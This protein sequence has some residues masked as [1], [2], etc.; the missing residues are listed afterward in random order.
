MVTIKAL[1][2]SKFLVSGL[3][4]YKLYLDAAA[5]V[6]EPGEGVVVALA[7]LVVPRHRFDLFGVLFRVPRQQT[8]VCIVDP[9]E[10][11][12]H[13]QIGTPE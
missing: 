4:G 3:I 1:F 8:R 12:P 11:D 5:G 13:D 6:A 9:Y 7:P 10:V 2:Y